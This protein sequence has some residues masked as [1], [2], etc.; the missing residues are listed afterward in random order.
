M[1]KDPAVLF[2]TSDFLSGTSFFSYEEKGRYITLL[3][4]QHQKN[5][6]PENH[7]I[8]ICES[9]DSQVAKKFVKGEDGLYRNQRMA[10]ESERRR[11]YC[12]SRSNNKSGRP[13][14][15]HKKIIRKSYDSD[16]NIHME[17]E[18]D[19]E[20]VNENKDTIKK[21]DKDMIVFK[22][23]I[24]DFN[25]VMGKRI[26]RSKKD[27]EFIEARLKEGFTLE[28]FKVVNR[29]MLKRWG[30]DEKMCHCLRPATL[31]SNKFES[32][33]NMIEPQT[34]LTEVG[35]KALQVGQSWLKNK[36]ERE[37]VR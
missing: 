37:N 17:T 36:K 32:Y 30:N 10:D 26:G 33:L 15:N 19:N 4:Q 7:M 35:V 12:D 13:S 9:L 27:R 24:T 18:T 11:N 31:Y 25:L 14:K 3:C 2:Y 22:E 16:M 1:A 23:I 21:E 34:K 20:N 8:N 28:E 5:G 29:K 6:I